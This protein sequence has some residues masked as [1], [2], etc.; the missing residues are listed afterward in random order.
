[1][2]KWAKFSSAKSH[3]TYKKLR[4]LQ[5]TEKRQNVWEREE[6]E[7][8]ERKVR[9]SDRDERKGWMREW[10]RCYDDYIKIYMVY[11]RRVKWKEKCKKWKEN[12]EENGKTSKITSSKVRLTGVDNLQFVFRMYAPV[13]SR[14]TTFFLPN[15]PAIFFLLL[16]YP[17]LFFNTWC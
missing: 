11:I 6:V 14:R 4:G 5:S 15:F 9:K 10:R 8:N 12:R 17:S 1:M 13:N 16:F 3:S 2:I 7:G